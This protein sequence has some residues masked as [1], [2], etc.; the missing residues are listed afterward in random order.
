[1]TDGSRN[2]PTDIP[3][4]SFLQPLHSVLVIYWGGG[5]NLSVL[6][7]PVYE[8]QEVFCRLCRCAV[9]RVFLKSTYCFRSMGL[10]GRRGDDPTCHYRLE[11]R[12]C[13]RRVYSNPSFLVHFFPLDEWARLNNG[14]KL[15]LL[16]ELGEE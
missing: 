1:M 13:F 4:E 2:M 5:P 6:Q 12:I 11:N 7:T 16:T 3:S 15:M 9:R 14:G 8:I 10:N